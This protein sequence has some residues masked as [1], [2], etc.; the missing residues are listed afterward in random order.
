[1]KRFL[2]PAR[3]YNGRETVMAS[4]TTCPYWP[5][6]PA[7]SPLIFRGIALIIALIVL[8]ALDVMAVCAVA[9]R[10]DSKPTDRDAGE[11]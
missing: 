9:I 7:G 6:R 4:Q 10:L 3:Y 2:W 8:T 5:P 1:V 11:S